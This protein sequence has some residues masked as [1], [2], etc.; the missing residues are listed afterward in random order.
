MSKD[1]RLNTT[2]KA[3]FSSIV[4][5][6]VFLRRIFEYNIKKRTLL[7]PSIF[8]I[9]TINLCNGSCIMCPLAKNSNNESMVM[10][11][12]LFEKIVKEISQEQLKRKKT[13]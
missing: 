5:H 6:G 12:R 3:G 8:C 1:M 4:Q 10:S 11:D 2:S 13:L 7:F 9:Q